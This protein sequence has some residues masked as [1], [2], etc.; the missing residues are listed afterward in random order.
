MKNILIYLS[1]LLLSAACT[2]QTPGYFIGVS[3]CSDDEWRHKMNNEILR[4]ALFYENV[5]VEIRTAKDNNQNQ[6]E[7]IGYFIEKGVDL[8]I[9]A[10]N[11]AI[12][13]TPVVEE[14]YNRGI[15]VIVVD[16]KILSDKYTAFVG[17]DNYEI[18][19]TVGN[20]IAT[21]LDGKGNI[22]ELTGLS[23]STPA[24]ERHQGLVSAISNC[25]GI[26]LL[27]SMDAEWLQS[28]A[29]EKMDTILEQFPDVDLVFAQ[30]DRMALGAYLS[31]WRKNKNSDIAFIG[32]D[33]LPGREYGVDQVLKGILDATFIYPTGGDVIIQTAMSI[34]QNQPFQRENLLSTALVDAT[35]ARVMKLQTEHITHQDGKIEL[36]NTKVNEYF[37][38]YVNQQIILYASLAVLL[39][40]VIASLI[41]FRAYRAKKRL[42]VELSQKHDEISRQKEQLESQRDQLIT[43]SRQLEEATHA[44][45]AFF[46]NVSHDF[47]TPLT[48]ISDPVAHLLESDELTPEQNHLL[49]IVKKN[50]NILLRLVNQILDFRKYEN[51]KLELQLSKQN[52]KAHIQEWNNAF[53]PKAIKK[54]IKFQFEA[55]EEDD[56]YLIEMD[57]DKVERVY[58]NLLSNAFKF[59]PE[60]GKIHIR[61]SSLYENEKCFIC[62]SIQDTGVGISPEHIKNIFNRFYKIDHHHDGSGI[63]LALVKAFVEMHQGIIEVESN[64]GAGTLF[65]VK[66]PVVQGVGKEE[67][68]L[69]SGEAGEFGSRS[70]FM[71]EIPDQVRDDRCRD[72]IDRDDK[73][74]F[75]MTS[76]N[77]DKEVILIIDDNPDIR[78]YVRYLFQENYTV[79]EAADGRAGLKSAMKYIPDIIICDVM[80]PEMDGIECCQLLKSELQ[81]SHIPV[82]LLTACSLD[83][84]RI[85]GF[86]NGADSYIS[87]PFNSNVLEARIRNLIDNR[88]R[89]KQF[90]GDNISLAKESINDI[91]KGFVEKFKTLIEENLSNPELNVEELG[92]NMGMSRVQLYRKIK[93]L[94][95]YAPNELLRIARLKRAASLLS[96]SEMTIAEITYEVGF[97]SPSYFTKCYKEYFRELPTEFLKR[98]G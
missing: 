97:T 91:D 15:P 55:P 69:G 1:A 2:T 59:T 44:K 70:G 37:S 25:P 64:V 53:L 74:T 67:Y 10:P 95:N 38:R 52:L 8:L 93:S 83:E 18:G 39:L 20:Y 76:L 56:N 62:L 65:T 23:G 13:I 66:L 43:L 33:A 63:G 79:I 82:I 34:L 48:L 3:Q 57:V 54:H 61:L 60:N 16:R 11:E 14:A 31:A 4:E 49:K 96:S 92:R 77:P 6:I 46:T 89:M 32:I 86:E 68:G 73:Y 28:V 29:T 42:N 94:T 5:N 98:K 30:N 26:K 78:D 36:L 80:M 81:T 9:V 71:K 58:F 24:I 88:K 75:D 21:L 84:Q 35:N 72:D 50:I 45:L 22:V 47:R 27:A 90:F 7:D 40:F 85:Q 17:A 19:K 41:I 51:G 87:K 12:P